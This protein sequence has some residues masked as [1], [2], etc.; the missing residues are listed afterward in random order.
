MTEIVLAESAPTLP[1]NTLRR[2]AN[3]GGNTER[4]KRQFTL[5]RSELGQDYLQQLKDRIG[6]L[7]E[8]VIIAVE[9]QKGQLS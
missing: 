9:N 5:L 8:E 2:I 4:A 3:I 1:T 6:A 7:H